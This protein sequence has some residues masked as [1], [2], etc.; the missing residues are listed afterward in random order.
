[1]DPILLNDRSP[2]AIMSHVMKTLERLVPQHLRAMDSLLVEFQAD[3]VVED[4]ITCRLYIAYIDL[5][6]PAQEAPGLMDG[7][8]I[9]GELERK[10]C[11]VAGLKQ[12]SVETVTE[13][14]ISLKLSQTTTLILPT[15]S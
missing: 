7:A 8:N 4:V 6:K 9:P 14:R 5:K 12:D 15:P 11:S 3:S 10:A 2:A 13:K 1:M